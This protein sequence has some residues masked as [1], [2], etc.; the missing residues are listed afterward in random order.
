MFFYILYRIG[1]FVSN[2]LPLKMMY[3]LA[4]RFADARY[5]VARKDREAVARNLSIV[6]KKDIAECRRMARNVFRNFGLYM[7]DFFR[8]ARLDKDLLKDM[9]QVEGI[10]NLDNVLKQGKGVIALSCHMGNWEL[11]GV[12]VAMLGYDI[13]AV[14]LTHKHDK[15]ND[16]FIRQREEK[17]LKAITIN[18]VMKRCLS[19]LLNKKILALVGDR[20]FTNSGI[21][22]DFFGVPMSI[23]KGP[24][25]LSI[26]TDSP[27]VP[28]FC[29]RKDRFSYKLIFDKPI[30]ALDVK[31][32]A[33]KIVRVMEK[34]IYTYP[35]QW[36]I[37]RRFWEKPK[38]AF[39]V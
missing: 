8:M 32:T 37:F 24:V 29:V 6:L 10:E 35:E 16:F 21:T 31:G 18:S 36:F 7:V 39:A 20:N 17:G 1:Y 15:I 3:W 30:E 34:Y 11:G 22:L 26:K 38:D 33:E 14:V 25:A 27:I 13:S 12:A 2:A 23:P 19:V 28:V 4:D 5:A 9:V